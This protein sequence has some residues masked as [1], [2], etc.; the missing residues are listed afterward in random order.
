ME[1]AKINGAGARAILRGA[2]VAKMLARE[3][4]IIAEAA[5]PGFDSSSE[6]GP[7]RARAE[8][9]ARTVA[10]RRAEARSRVLTI[11]MGS[12]MRK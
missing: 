9:Y 6:V 11:A 10:A 1:K 7:N 5:G 2:P 4:E 8:V 12:R 3:A